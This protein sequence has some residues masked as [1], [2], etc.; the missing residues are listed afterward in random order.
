ML[1]KIYARCQLGTTTT[2][3]PPIRVIISLWLWLVGHTRIKVKYTAKP[4]A[5]KMRK[6]IVLYESVMMAWRR[7]CIVS[8]GQAPTTML[9]DHNRKNYIA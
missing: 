6:R 9:L 4:I 7:I 5:V 8:V 1:I 2:I 3:I